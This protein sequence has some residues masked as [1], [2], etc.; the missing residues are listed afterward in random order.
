MVRIKIYFFYH[1]ASPE[2]IFTAEKLE[3]YCCFLEL[4]EVCELLSADHRWMQKVLTSKQLDDG[5]LTDMSALE[6]TKL[7]DILCRTLYSRLFTWLIN[8]INDSIKVSF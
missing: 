3:A 5:V 6:A 7:R 4:F 8:K 1:F 2:L